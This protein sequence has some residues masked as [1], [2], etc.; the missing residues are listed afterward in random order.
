MFA[1]L[2]ALVFGYATQNRLRSAITLFAV[3]LGVAIALAIDLA[4]HTAVASFSTSVDIVSNHVNLQVLGIG[5]GFDERTLVRVQD[6]EGV[7]YAGPVIEDSIVIGARRGEPL[8]GEILHVMG[9]DVLRPL[10]G[11][12]TGGA[13]RSG[14]SGAASDTP[15]PNVMV[16]AH[17]ALISARLL[18]AHHLRVGATLEALSGD[19]VVHLKI[20]G[21]FPE[22]LAGIDSSVVF[23]DIATAQEVFAKIGRIDRIDVVAPPAQ[24]ARVE[25]AVR[26]VLPPGVRVIEP[27]VRTSEIRR[28]L[29]SFE[30]NLAAL[31]YVAL[32]VGG[33]LIYNTVAIAVVQRRAEIGTVRA[34]GATRA[35]VFLA[36]LA[37]GAIFGAA[38][39]LLGCGLGALLAQFSVQAV[40]KT[41]D[42]LY[43]ATH[44][45]RVIYDPMVFLKAV[46]IGIALAI[47]S[48]AV[49]ALEAARTAPAA[50]MRSAGFEARSGGNVARLAA[51]GA[52]AFA[53]AYLA[54][55]LP[56]IDDV[57]VFGYLAGLLIV[58]GVSLLAP[59]VLLGCARFVQ[60]L[61]A[62]GSVVVA[63]AATNARRS[64]F[65]TSVAVASLAVAVA[66]MVAV[67]ILIS[68]FR[69]TVVAWANDTIQADIF[70]RPPGL[71]DASYDARFSPN[72]VAAMRAVAGVRALD[73][74]RGISMP[75]RGRIIAVGASDFGELDTR[76]KLR[77]VGAYDL[78]R[79]AASLPGSMNVLVS[80]P[81]TTRFGLGIGDRFTLA[82]PSGKKTFL[83]AGVYN[84]YASDNGTLL[85][86]QRTFRR[87][88]RD[89]SVNAIAIYAQPGID[90]AALRTRLIRSV[91]P[92]QIDTQTSRELR[93]FV[94]TIFN[95]TFA[96]T[97][98]LYV[99]SMTVAVLG[100]IS[101]LFALVLERRRETGILRYLGLTRGG[102]R[103]MV[104]TEAALVG[105]LGGF[106]GIA[107]GV[108]LSLLL[109]F[110]INRQAF[111]WLI[112][113]HMP[114]DFLVQAFV[115]VVVAALIAGIFP[116]AVAARIRTAD[117]VRSE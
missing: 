60:A 24:L 59:P 93:E 57:P 16:N 42:T 6:I 84:D 106:L 86:D 43:V 40:T 25:A 96:I 38:G 108:L 75:F 111:G 54:T 62:R 98:A 81:F 11:G 8:S 56:A 9:I 90:L 94:L 47:V 12:G 58:A 21:A 109:I 36:F 10:P 70:V 53:L 14:V 68:S 49:P 83:I 88:F 79:L 113:L 103:R 5:N 3:A 97:Y 61:A 23:V 105:T 110:V 20:A 13:F 41:V 52:G 107:A 99:I 45:D 64:L 48:A 73:A 78:H 117:A 66:M 34:L 116:A 92:L 71:Q 50:S 35:S 30:M 87:L 69:T 102:V 17:G 95:R 104:F 89:D 80:E 39:S 74:F 37:E 72:V 77:M 22:K 85:I 44:A 82:T 76:R 2:R 28:M 26:A 4:N 100:V 112:E 33:Y 1:L 7:A 91:A 115:L 101:T 31:S 27:R 51:L 32:L 114:Y 19:R 29:R 63:L 18:A 65:R 67:A 46:L 15:D 55:R